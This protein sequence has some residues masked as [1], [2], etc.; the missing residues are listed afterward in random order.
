M[1]SKE[2]GQKGRRRKNA[3]R[4]GGTN[5][6][7]PPAE[8]E[9][10]FLYRLNSDVLVQQLGGEDEKVERD[11][12]QEDE[13]GAGGRDK[14]GEDVGEDREGELASWLQHRKLVNNRRSS[15]TD[16]LVRLTEGML[17]C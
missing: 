8:Q 11:A 16:A 3:S 14:V 4:N 12:A 1:F 9:E 15:G 13:G 5:V 17:G 10:Q 6:A 2:G 7:G